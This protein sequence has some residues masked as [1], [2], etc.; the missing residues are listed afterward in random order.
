MAR[1]PIRQGVPLSKGSLVGFHER[2]S[3]VIT[4]GRVAYTMSVS[5]TNSIA[6]MIKPGD[7]IDIFL[8]F[9]SDQELAGPR[10]NLNTGSRTTTVIEN[11]LILATGNLIEETIGIEGGGYGTIT[12]EVE[13]RQAEQLTIAQASGSFRVILRN[14]DDQSPFGLGGLAPVRGGRTPPVER[15]GR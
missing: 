7:R 14:T 8:V 9:N 11:L 12:V 1:V 2:F 13:P 4:P 5:E 10:T 15:L 3:R 6:G